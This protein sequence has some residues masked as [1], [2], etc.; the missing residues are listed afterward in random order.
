MLMFQLIV[1]SLSLSCAH[2]YS[3]YYQHKTVLPGWAI[4]EGSKFSE[5]VT[6]LIKNVGNVFM[7]FHKS[8]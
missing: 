7:L 3:N 5:G 1:G 6:I 8:F 4:R 2:V